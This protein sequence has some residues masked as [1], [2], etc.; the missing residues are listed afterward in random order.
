MVGGMAP[1]FSR[2]MSAA[3]GAYGVFALVFPRHLG[4]VLTDDRRQQQSYDLVA[5]TYG[6]RDLAVSAVGVLGRS[7]DAVR[8]AMF[9]RIGFDLT[10]AMVLAPLAQDPRARNKILG[11]TLGWATLNTVA[12]LVDRRG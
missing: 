7:P 4:G 6:F 3:T 12:V 11:A 9:I 1:T 2:V 8:A 5:T 10:D